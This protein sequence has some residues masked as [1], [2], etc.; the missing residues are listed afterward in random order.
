MT[1]AAR[2]HILGI[3]GLRW[4]GANPTVAADPVERIVAVALANR[5]AAE[6]EKID[7]G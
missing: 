4:L 3:D 1:D 7:R 2:L 6:Q 5:V